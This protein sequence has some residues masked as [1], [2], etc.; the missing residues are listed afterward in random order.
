MIAPG[1]AA[2]RRGTD[3]AA[4]A[5]MHRATAGR[6]EKERVRDLDGDGDSDGESKGKGDEDGDPGSDG[7]DGLIGMDPR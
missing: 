6:S 3:S 1:S 7:I 5:A 4:N 2:A